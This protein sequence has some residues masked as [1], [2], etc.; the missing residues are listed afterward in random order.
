V[1]MLLARVKPAD[2]T[3]NGPL[4]GVFE[5]NDS[6]QS[7]GDLFLRDEHGDFWLA[8]TASEVVQTADGAALPAGARFALGTIPSVDLVVAYGV[9]DRG[10]ELLV[11]AVSL[12]PGGELSTGE[13]EKAMDKLPANQRP[14]YV[15]VVS[16]IPV[17]TWHR[18]LWRPIQ[19][20]GAPTPGRGRKVWRRADDGAH[21]EQ[22]T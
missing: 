18:P 19:A 5:P 17:T 1:G 9:P 8:G 10:A 4:R 20:K 21:Y 12:R 14:S 11:A 3:V 13:I 16:S 22:L 7:T 15:Q 2:P 6:W